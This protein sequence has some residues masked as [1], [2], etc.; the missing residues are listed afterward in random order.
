MTSVAARCTL[1]SPVFDRRGRLGGPT[2]PNSAR[3]TRQFHKMHGLGNDF[4]VLDGSRAAGDDD[5]GAGRRR[6]PTASSASAA[7]S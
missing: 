1:G 5:S 7:T 6:S 2:L 3:V 4:V